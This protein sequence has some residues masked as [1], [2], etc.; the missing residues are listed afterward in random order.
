MGRRAGDAV[1]GSGMPSVPADVRG[2][3]G[4]GETSEE[5]GRG[6]GLSRR[7][8]TRGAIGVCVAVAIGAAAGCSS[9]NGS[10]DT[11][12]TGVEGTRGTLTSTAWAGHRAAWRLAV[13][14]GR[15]PT[16]L[17]V[18]LHGKGGDADATFDLGFQKRCPTTGL[19]LVSVS[20]GDGYW[21]RRSDGRDAGGMVLDDLIP[22][23]RAVAKLPAEAPVGFIG[24]SM[25]GYGSLLLA[26]VLADRL[27]ARTPTGGA[28]GVLGVATMSAALWTSPGATAPGS[29]DDAEDYRAHDVFDKEHRLAGI[30]VSMDC[31]TADPFIA[32]NRAYVSRRTTARHTFDDGGHTGGYW[33]AHA[34]P[35]LAWL[36]GQVSPR[37]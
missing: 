23:A 33:S 32:A 13:P 2:R 3:H 4:P 28:G 12:V 15:T 31:G 24:W 5:P 11:S 1:Y 34:G 20:G 19:A 7:A 18:S 36:A 25:G 22:L 14:T 17:V 10:E 9:A 21:H 30:P 35:Q 26:R 6:E 27:S 29:F 16:A 8:V 37:R